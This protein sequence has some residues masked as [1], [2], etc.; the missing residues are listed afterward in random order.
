MG[1]SPNLPPKL[2]NAN[3]QIHFCSIRIRDLVCLEIPPRTVFMFYFHS[4]LC[5]SLRERVC[6]QLNER[7]SELPFFI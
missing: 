4:P 2:L 6:V 5:F 7:G 3:H 1:D